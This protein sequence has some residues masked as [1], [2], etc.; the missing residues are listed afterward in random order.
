M[1]PQ[2]WVWRAPALRAGG[3]KGAFGAFLFHFP[4]AKLGFEEKL[5]GQG[6][7]PLLGQSGARWGIEGGLQHT[8][9]WGT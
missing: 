7:W 9:A 3:A 1:W 4:T 6:W 2:E 5:V 8:P